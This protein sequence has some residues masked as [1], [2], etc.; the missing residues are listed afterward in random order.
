MNLKMFVMA[1]LGA[2]C[3]TATAAESHYWKLGV[4]SYGAGSGAEDW[5][6]GFTDLDR[7][8]MDWVFVNLGSEKTTGTELNRLLA[9][10][11]ALKI[12]VQLWPIG[13]IGPHPENR[14]Q[15]TFL[16]YLY[17]DGV[18]AKL[19]AETSRQI[20]SILDP[21]TKPENVVGFTF[22]EELPCH[23]TGEELSK[24]DPAPL[25]WALALY[26]KQIE[27]ERGQPLVWD[28]AT[29]RWWGQKFVQVLN[30]INAHIKKESGGKMV[31]VYIQT[32][33]SILD[34]EPADTDLQR[35]HLLPFHYRDVIK[36][37]VADGYF[38]YPNSAEHWKIFTRPAIENNWPFFCQVAHAGPMHLCRWDERVALAETKLPQNLG[39]FFFCDGNCYTRAWNDDPTIPANDSFRRASVRSHY[40]RFCAQRGVGLDIVKRHLTPTLQI[41][42]NTETTKPGDWVSLNL[43]VHNT[44][45]AAW[46]LPPDDLTLQ[47]VTATVEPPTGI[48]LPKDAS[49]PATVELGDIGPD[50]VTSIQWWGKAGQAVRVGPDKPLTVRLTAANCPPVSGTWTT[51]SAIIEPPAFREVRQS[52]EQWVWPAYHLK[53][54]GQVPTTVTLQCVSET[55][56]NPQLIIGSGNFLWQGCLT[57][58]QTLVV[59]PGRKALLKDPAFPEGRDVTDRLG[60]KGAQLSGNRLNQLTY[61]DDD[62]PSPAAKLKITLETTP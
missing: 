33:H 14:G 38:I 9:L 55:A 35:T 12:L 51:P 6:S 37:G 46:H 47:R 22:L 36:P 3:L 21:I 11:P 39:Y 24:I 30:E 53:T 44:R 23:F 54:D 32:N 58:G 2:G 1:A 56:T 31:Y 5:W 41:E 62:V 45:T 18:K 16:D 10:N 17:A 60:G 57:N 26:Q 40:R 20:R 49:S 27:A 52:G 59:G 25:N 29:R 8:R 7:A 50:Q 48:T 15:A 42:Y 61:L 13:N 28:A 43:L 4:G 34:F 19:L